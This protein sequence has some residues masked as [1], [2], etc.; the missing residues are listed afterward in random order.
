M[1]IPLARVDVYQEM[2]NRKKCANPDLKHRHIHSCHGR[3]EEYEQART[4]HV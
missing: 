3:T 2:D 4:S 1:S